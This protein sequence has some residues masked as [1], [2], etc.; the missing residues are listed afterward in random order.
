M[1][2][3]LNVVFHGSFCFWFRP[4]TVYVMMPQIHG[5][6]YGLG[7]PNNEVMLEPGEYTLSI[8]TNSAQGKLDPS[9]NLVVYEGIVKRPDY[10]ACH[11]WI[12]LPEPDDIK[13]TLPVD[14][15]HLVPTQTTRENNISVSQV[16]LATT[17]IYNT[18]P[19]KAKIYPPI[20]TAPNQVQ[21]NPVQLHIHAESKF[22]PG[23]SHVSYSL[24]SLCRLFSPALDLR[25]AANADLP[26]Q[27]SAETIQEL[28]DEDVR[29]E[30]VSIRNC[31]SISVVPGI[32]TFRN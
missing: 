21:A 29:I 7:Y 20:W 11:A 4:G 24:A 30:S 1:P 18:D 17:F 28:S 10:R 31:L 9:R 13:P 6:S 27:P 3:S 15:A 22:T 25:F 23:R 12:A 26:A 2:E 16:F 5:H 32:P 14:L 19:R 8:P